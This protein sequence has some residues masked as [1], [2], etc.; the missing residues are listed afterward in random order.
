MKEERGAI[1]LEV[2]LQ[3]RNGCAAPTLRWANMFLSGQCFLAGFFF[4]VSA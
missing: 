2:F 1:D 4:A 3:E